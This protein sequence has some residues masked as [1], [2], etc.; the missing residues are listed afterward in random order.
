M[1]VR[2]ETKEMAQPPDMRASRDI[3]ERR[4]PRGD[5][6][7]K[8]PRMWRWMVA[9]LV[10]VL[11]SGA[12]IAT[13]ASRADAATAIC[14]GPISARSAGIY[15]PGMTLT[16]SRWC[17]M[18]GNGARFTTTPTWT[19]TYAETAVYHFSKWFPNTSQSGTGTA[20]NGNTNVAYR[21]R[22]SSV[23]FI[24]CLP[25]CVL[26]SYP[27]GVR[28]WAWANGN[29]QVAQTSTVPTLPMPRP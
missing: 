3:G 18:T 10:M 21:A 17:G 28:I 24:A 26:H 15:P 27:H 1:D 9:I 5:L 23:E 22:W 29:Y 12:L 4:S 16:A 11:V 6:T 19:R 8:P 2:V 14:R 20:P 7:S 13:Q 25:N